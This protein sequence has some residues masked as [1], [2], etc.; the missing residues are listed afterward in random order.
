MSLKDI[1]HEPFT[2]VILDN[3]KKDPENKEEIRD[4]LTR[5][6]KAIEEIRHRLGE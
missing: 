4:W 2:H 5:L 1:A 3:C 6:E